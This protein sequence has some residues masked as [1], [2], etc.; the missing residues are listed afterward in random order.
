MPPPREPDGERD[1]FMS[2]PK[3][4]PIA[5]E[6]D[7]DDPPPLPSPLR[8]VL[9]LPSPAHEKPPIDERRRRWA[10]PREHSKKL[11]R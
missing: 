8:L 9:L 3:P 6:A 10:P 11:L 2:M 7:E 1:E 5:D 4:P